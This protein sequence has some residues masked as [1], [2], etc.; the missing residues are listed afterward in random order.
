MYRLA[1]WGAAIT[2]ALTVAAG[3]ATA[4][5][6]ELRIGYQPNPIQ[7][8]SIAMFEAWGAKNGIKIIKVP[9]SYG[10]YVEKMT[11][12]LTSGSDQ[13]DVIWHNDDW[14]QLWCKLLEPTNDVKGLEKVQ[15]WVMEGIIF[16]NEQGQTT[17]VPM[18]HT[19]VSFF[20]R[21]DL[22]KE[23]ELP[24]TWDDMVK[25]S[26]RLQKEGK[27]KYGFVGGM[28]MNNTWF[29]WLWLMWTNNCDVL[30]PVFNR[31]N[32]VLAQNGFKPLLDQPCMQQSAEFWW[33]AI[34]TYKISPRGMPAY[35]RNEANAVFM[36]GDAV[37]T[38]ADSTFHGLFNDP[39]KS[40]IAGKV[41]IAHFPLGPNRKQGDYFVLNDIWGWAIPR[42][43]SEERKKLA[44]QMLSAYLLDEEGQIQMWNKTGGPPPNMDAW[45][46]I[47]DPFWERVR[48]FNL[49]LK[50]SVHGGYYFANWPG[51]H[52]AFSDVVTK[53]IIGKR[54]DIPK[55]LKDGMQSVHDAATK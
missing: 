37:F 51:M 29:S 39:S 35:D 15:P 32:K 23:S 19:L 33:D 2:T 1:K 52:K 34:H 55:V 26:Q 12:S 16:N 8:A 53:A 20:Y 22:V 28:S 54:E 41:N 21:T 36:A 48:A 11:A 10:V 42:A 40:K 9:N 47:H 43:L 6:K 31:D 5:V 17:V 25:I 13:Y 18:V 30:Q 44:K 4:Q 50:P 27:V 49:D 24:K 14:G 38:A 46:K 7:D 3:A 45:K